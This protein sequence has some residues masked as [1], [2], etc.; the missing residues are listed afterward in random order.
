RRAS[1]AQC[2]TA[3]RRLARYRAGSA[4]RSRSSSTLRHADA[5]VADNAPA[6][7]MGASL[8]RLA[9]V[10]WVARDRHVDECAMAGA[11]GLVRGA[12]EIRIDGHGDGRAIAGGSGRYAARVARRYA[13]PARDGAGADPDP[14]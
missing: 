9:G 13:V 5:A 2:R 7:R 10:A 12:R 14:R 3:T 8:V 6:A 4:F 11:R 1:L